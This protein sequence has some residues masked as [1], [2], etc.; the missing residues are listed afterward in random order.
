MKRT[1]KRWRRFGAKVTYK[2]VRASTYYT[3]GDTLQDGET[4]VS[5][6]QAPNAGLTSVTT[7]AVLIYGSTDLGTAV[8]GT[9]PARA[10]VRGLRCSGMVAPSETS[11]E[12]FFINV[13]PWLMI[14][15]GVVQTD[16][17]TN[18]RSPQDATLA[19]LSNA[20]PFRILTPWKVHSMWTGPAVNRPQ[21]VARFNLRAPR[22]FTVPFP[23]QVY[24]FFAISTLHDDTT[25]GIPNAAMSLTYNFTGRV[26]SPNR[27]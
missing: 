12:N 10:K 6:L 4:N 22:S 9:K 21:Q 15:P 11:A 18:N 27:S 19:G 7:Q 13:M 25:V 17:I 23:H 1:Y 3:W 16:W 5:T 26:Q 14:C 24:L 8:S 2:G 20:N